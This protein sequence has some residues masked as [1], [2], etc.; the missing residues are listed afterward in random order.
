MCKPTKYHLLIG[1]LLF[2]LVVN[3]QPF[4]LHKRRAARRLHEFGVGVTTAGP[5]ILE[6]R[7]GTIP[8]QQM[9]LVGFFINYQQ[10]IERSRLN[11]TWGSRLQVSFYKGWWNLGTAVPYYQPSVTSFSLDKLDQA[12]LFLYLQP[13]KTLLYRKSFSVSVVAKAGPAFSINNHLNR[14]EGL[15]ETRS[16]N[17]MAFQVCNVYQEKR[18]PLWLPYLRVGAGLEFSFKTKKG[19]LLLVSPFWETK[20][21]QV[22]KL[23]F[24]NLPEDAQLISS[25]HFSP[26]RHQAGLQFL[27][28]SHRQNR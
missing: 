17:G 23:K 6:P 20:V 5:K 24:T 9:A 28:S 27:W 18:Q 15:V 19:N 2:S 7:Q 26:H 4:S 13:G 14:T 10:A 3:A 22:D 8:L 21:L 1:L 25:G 16:D 11:L 12:E